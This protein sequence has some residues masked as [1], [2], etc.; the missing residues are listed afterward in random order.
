M[1]DDREFETWVLTVPPEITSDTIWRTPAYR[2]SLYHMFCAQSDLRWI[3][4]HRST[5]ALGDQLLRAVGGISANL[6]E[7]YSRSSGRE[8]ALFY[9]YALGSARESRGWYYKCSVALPPEI[10][11]ARLGRLSRI[12]RILTSVIP[13]EREKDNVWRP[14]RNPAG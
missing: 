12:V 13:R 1:T 2:F 7:G 4:R 5:R 10:T 3:S 11:T 8:R 6:D 9:E 14:R